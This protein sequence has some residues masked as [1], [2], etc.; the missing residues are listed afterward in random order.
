MVDTDRIPAT[1]MSLIERNSR[2][3]GQGNSQVH[4]RPTPKLANDAVLAT[5]G[6]YGFVR[7]CQAVYRAA[8]GELGN[9]MTV[10][11]GS[12]GPEANGVVDAGG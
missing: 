11:I 4:T 3:G 9:Q 7:H 10:V 8:S 5:E 1:E 12:G 6:Q 2:I